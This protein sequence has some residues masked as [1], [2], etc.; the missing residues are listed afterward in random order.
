[1]VLAEPEVHK[2]ISKGKTIEVKI[3]PL[4]FED[5][6]KM[7]KLE[8]DE[9]GKIILSKS[10]GVLTELMKKKIRQSFTEL[11]NKGEKVVPSDEDI[12]KMDVNVYTQ[13]MEK[14][15]DMVQ[16]MDSDVKK[17]GECKASKDIGDQRT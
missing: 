3:W 17:K 8:R 11:N 4:D 13:Y 15:F 6:M 1:M 5:T 16:R 14:L 9:T 10:S 2:L 12:M 7:M